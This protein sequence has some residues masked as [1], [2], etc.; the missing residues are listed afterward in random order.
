MPQLLTRVLVAQDGGAIYVYQGSGSTRLVGC[1]FELNAA[2]FGGAVWAADRSGP[3]TIADC[4][5]RRNRASSVRTTRVV[6]LA[7][8]RRPHAHE[9]PCAG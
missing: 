6:P 1:A 9:S 5:F 3:T 2:S 7:C 4:V 8:H